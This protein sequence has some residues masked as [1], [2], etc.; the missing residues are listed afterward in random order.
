MTVSPMACDCAAAASNRRRAAA[1]A[2]PGGWLL[3]R[4]T[5][6]ERQRPQVDPARA[7]E[8]P[9]PVAL[10]Q[11]VDAHLL[12]RPRRMDE[13]VVT[14]VDAHV[15]EGAPHGVEEHQV[16]GLELVAPDLEQPRRAGF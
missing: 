1:R 7:G 2:A 11:V 16:A 12:A 9:R 4:R 13:L 15:R 8:A 3:Q 5:C 10:A 14:D 6:G